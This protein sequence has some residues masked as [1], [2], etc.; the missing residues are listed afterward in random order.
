MTSLRPPL[1]VGC[2]QLPRSARPSDDAVHPVA[3]PSARSRRS[4]ACSSGPG[5]YARRRPC[6]TRSPIVRRPLSETRCGTT[7]ISCLAQTHLLT[8][9]R[10]PLALRQL[11]G[12]SVL[13]TTPTLPQMLLTVTHRRHEPPGRR[14][15]DIDELDGTDERPGRAAARLH[16]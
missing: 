4:L 13:S 1:M 5:D 9:V 10:S 16:R 2:P 6:G 3:Q 15:G 7:L 14:S 12:T 11:T 8:P